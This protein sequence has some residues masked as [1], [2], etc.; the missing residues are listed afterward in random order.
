MI[1]SN[2]HTH[3]VFCDG[4]DTPEELVTEAIKK[5]FIALGFSGHSYFEQDKEYCM[6][7]QSA[8]EYRQTVNALKD[9]YKKDIHILCGI[10]QDYYSET[11]V[12]IYDYVIGSVHNVLKDGKY[13]SV[14]ASPEIFRANLVTYYGGDF[15]AFAED[16]FAVMADVVNKTNADIIGHF[17][18]ILRFSEKLGYTPT[19]RFLA[20]AEKAVD[21][22]VKF[23]RPFEINTGA[24]AR[25]SRSIPYPIPEILK[26]IKEKGG[27]IVFS[28]DCH[29]KAHLDCAFTVAEKLA[30]DCGFTEH[31]ILTGEGIEYI[32]IL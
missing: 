27:K 15:D 32:P 26:M 14:D 18:L 1:K 23:D 11:P 29:A 5:G 4:A 30:K 3:T 6:D 10:E 17:D 2:F 21:A 9:K 24:M 8:R 25:G 13:L 20:A 28:S 19:P 7:E 12:F 16:Y 31:G 22:L